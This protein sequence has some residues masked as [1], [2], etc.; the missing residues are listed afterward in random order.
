[1]K[2]KSLLTTINQFFTIL[3][4]PD[5]TQL[6][7][8][9]FLMLGGMFIEMIGLG[10]IMPLVSFLINTDYAGQFPFIKNT[11]QIIFGDSSS[12]SIVYIGLFCILAIF[13]IKALYLSFY[14]WK[15]TF[16]VFTLNQTIGERLFSTYINQPYIFHVNH[17]SSRMIQNLIGEVGI[18]TGT[19]MMTFTIIIAESLV[20][21]GILSVLLYF[22]PIP[23]LIIAGSLLFFSY[24]YSLLTKKSINK[25]G[26]W[27]Q[28]ADTLRVQRVQEGFNGIKESFLLGR[29]KFFQNQFNVQNKQSCNVNANQ[30]F[31]LNLPKIWLEFIAIV[32]ILFMII[33]VSNDKN[34]GLVD[35]LPS[36][37]LFGAA[38][39]RVLPSINRIL[40]SSQLLRFSIPNISRLYNELQIIIPKNTNS[41]S[42]KKIKF[43]KQISLKNVSFAYPESN[44][45]ILD[46]CSLNIYAGECLGIVG[47][48]GAGKSTLVDN[49]LGLFIP[50]SGKII[51]DGQDI[52][53]NMRSW[54]DQIGYVSQNL[55]LM[56]T[57]IT[58][59]VAFGITPEKINIK[60]VKKALKMAQLDEFISSLPDG[61][62]TVLG[63][64]GVKL[65]GGQ[66]QRI[67]IAR[68]L[69]H[70]P[71]VIILDEAT[72]ALDSKTEIEVMKSVL[73]LKGSKTII[74]I[75]HRL[76][77][78]K[79]CDRIFRVS[80]GGKVKVV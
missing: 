62:D 7:F 49:I 10:L 24:L 73:S 28:I 68:A 35:V 74:M 70:N 75:A 71:S 61:M 30:T 2:K 25:W 22:Q 29:T 19:V 52:Q 50:N 8:I 9:I 48:S 78:L 31:I 66:R 11:S 53:N 14:T 41:K 55:F 60:S 43:K 59:N 33:L 12:S 34:A 21:I 47:A 27:R 39:F 46:N 45:K 69:Y 13:F 80:A 58:S 15:Q 57:T 18:F 40:N 56:D 17:N 63:E 6:F 65:S 3:K 23:T 77:T 54:Q 44:K 37:A 42:S 72:N 20:L 5:Q 51:V 32:A 16:F 1:M 76:S 38:A 26:T 79:K 64:R 4:K 36:L 67:G